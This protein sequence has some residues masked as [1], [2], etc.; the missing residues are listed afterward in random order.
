MYCEQIKMSEFEVKHKLH[1]DEACSDTP[2]LDK[3]TRREFNKPFKFQ[4]F[5]ATKNKLPTKNRYLK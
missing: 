4:I 2:S 1:H 5:S 3:K